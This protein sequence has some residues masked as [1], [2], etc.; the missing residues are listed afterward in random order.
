MTRPYRE[1]PVLFGSERSLFGILCEPTD[2]GG[3][4]GPAVVMSSAGVLHRVGANRIHVLHARALARSGITSLRFDLSGVGDSARRAGVMTLNEAVELDLKEALDFVG[5]SRGIDS[6]I[7]FGLCS[8][9]YDGL[10]LAVRDRRVA[11]VV[12]IDVFAEYRT[13]RYVLTHYGRRILRWGSWR[14][15]IARP[16]AALSVLAHRVRRAEPSGSDAIV[17][18]RPSLSYAQLDSIL[19]TLGNRGVRSLFLHTGGLEEEYNYEHQFRDCYPDHVR[20]G[21]VSH[22][23]FPA[24]THTFNRQRDR[25]ALLARVTRWIAETTFKPAG[26]DVPRQGVGAPSTMAGPV[27]T[28]LDEGVSPGRAG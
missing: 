5:T 16:R 22:G 20:S 7:L 6:F 3:W 23:Y 2:P 28:D 25:E 11:G 19:R 1:T 10:Q 4:D 15:A 8:A 21:L 18:V 17:G 26:R 24:S 13:A 12:A 9:A 14:R 27:A